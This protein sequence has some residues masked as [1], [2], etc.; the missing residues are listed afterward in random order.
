MRKAASPWRAALDLL[1]QARGLSWASGAATEAAWERVHLAEQ[2]LL[3][4]APTPALAAEKLHY[5]L[6]VL[7]TPALA[8]LRLS[9]QPWRHR[10]LRSAIDDVAALQATL[11]RA[12]AECRRLRRAAATSLAGQTSVLTEQLKTMRAELQAVGAERDAALAAVAR[13]NQRHLRPIAPGVGGI[14]RRH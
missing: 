7:Q 6:A 4:P 13:V 14:E 3:A 1:G 9:E 2:A 5:L 12:E 10:L 8:L 11:D